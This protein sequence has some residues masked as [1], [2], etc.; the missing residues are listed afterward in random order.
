[1]PP[2]AS[3]IKLFVSVGAKGLADTVITDNQKS[4]LCIIFL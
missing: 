3:S 2:A 1:M 4:M